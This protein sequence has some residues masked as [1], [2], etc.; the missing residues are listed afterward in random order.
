MVV[1]IAYLM[2]I[3]YIYKYQT[4]IFYHH[5][6]KYTH[7]CRCFSITLLPPDLLAQETEYAKLDRYLRLLGDKN[8]F[9]GSVSV[10][11]KGAEIYARSVDLPISI[12]KS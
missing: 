8:K 6:E 7:S 3:Q 5:D 2:E 9:M 10:F 12:N 1:G 11:S 4:T